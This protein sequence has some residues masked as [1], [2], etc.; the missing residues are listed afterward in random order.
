MS[1]EDVM[2][3]RSHTNVDHAR[4]RPV[5]ECA[6]C[7]TRLFGPEWSEYINEHRARH[8]WMCVSCG[9]DFETLVVF[10]ADAKARDD[11]AA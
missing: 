11:E 9:Y 8:L 10:P 6:Q 1:E 5:T 7:G 4:L 2:Q 3:V